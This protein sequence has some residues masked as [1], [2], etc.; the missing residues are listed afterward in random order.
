MSQMPRL[1][2]A[3]VTAARLERHALAVPLAGGTPAAIAARMCGVHAQVMTAAQWSI[4]LRLAGATR[5]DVQA[6]L[7]ADRSLVKTF[8]PRG[9]VHLLPAADLP[10]WTGALSALPRSHGGPASAYLS[11]EQAE[12]VLGAIGSALGSA[13][14]TVDELGEAVVEHC[15]SWAGDEVMP[16]FTGLWPRWRQAL[17]LAGARGMLCFGPDRGR[18]VTFTSPRRWLTGFEPASAKDGLSWLVTQY[19]TAYG[20]ATAD[21]F[22]RWLSVPRRVAATVFA[23]QAG[24]LQQV[25]LDGTPAWL[26]AGARPDATLSADRV[27]R[28]VRLLPYFDAYA[29][30]GQPRGRLFPGVATERALVGGKVG[31][32]AGTKPVLLV[33]GVVAGLWH[34]RK[35]ARSIAI[36]VEPFGELTAGQHRELADEARRLGEFY[37]SAA[38]LTL[39]RVAARSHL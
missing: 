33:D 18:N 13:E 15:G 31:G 17:T 30:G 6:A 38:V 10:R 32:Q 26:P 36:T 24:S 27:P 8:G 1:S 39:A 2:W 23:E 14:L 34:Q 3:Q 11:T 5:A 28:G 35:S 9:T 25:D 22:A 19:L 12:T 37:G 16:A 7:W 29:V 20:P 4:G 21:D